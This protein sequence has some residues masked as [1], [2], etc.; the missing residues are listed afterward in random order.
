VSRRALALLLA[1]VA[2]LP[3]AL[4]MGGFRG[5]SLVGVLLVVA[6][7]VLT[8]VGAPTSKGSQS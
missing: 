2:L 4:L 3:F 5:L 8:I 1:A 6:S 7:I